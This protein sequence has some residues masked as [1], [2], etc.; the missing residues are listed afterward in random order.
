MNLPGKKSTALEYGKS[1]SFLLVG[2]VLGAFLTPYFAFYIPQWFDNTAISYTKDISLKIMDKDAKSNVDLKINNE[3]IKKLFGQSIHIWNSGHKSINEL[4][5]TYYFGDEDEKF[6]IF[7]VIHNVSPLHEINFKLI[8]ESNNFKRFSYKNINPKDEFS[9]LFLANKNQTAC[10]HPTL[11]DG[12]CLGRTPSRPV[13]WNP[14]IAESSL[15]RS[16]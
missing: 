8:D 14:E 5:I 3:T 12:V 6:N 4:H 16:P 7:D 9:V 15:P 2:V 11:K 1:L 13:L 10:G